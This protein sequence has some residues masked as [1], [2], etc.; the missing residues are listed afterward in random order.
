MLLDLFTSGNPVEATIILFLLNIVIVLFALTVHE[1]S[2]GYVA[3]KLGDPTA[4]NL[5]RLTLNPMRHLDPIGALAM[6]LF[7]FGW[8]KPVPIN[9]RYFKNPRWGMALTAAAGPASN[10]L[11]AFANVLVLRLAFLLFG[12]QF[13]STPLFSIF[14]SFIMSAA[15]LNIALAIF[16]LLPIPPFDGSRIFYVFLPPKLYFGVMKYERLIMIGVLVLMMFGAFSG[17]LS[18]ITYFILNGMYFIVG[19]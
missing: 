1:V 9:S 6:L 5:G 13:G 17:L 10:L 7:G 12:A 11:L 4:R 14:I 19:F 18:N 16:N 2:H 3:Y 15:Y 8:A